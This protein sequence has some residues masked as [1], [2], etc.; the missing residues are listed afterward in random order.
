M[1]TAQCVVAVSSEDRTP[2]PQTKPSSKREVFFKRRAPSLVVPTTGPH[3]L[4]LASD[5][6]TPFEA[7][8]SAAAFRRLGGT[9]AAEA[10]AAGCD[11]AEVYA[12]CENWQE[13][14]KA[15]SMALL[16][17]DGR[18]VTV[19]SRDSDQ[20]GPW[21]LDGASVSTD[22]LRQNYRPVRW[23]AALRAALSDEQMLGA[24]AFCA[25]G[26]TAAEAE[27][28]G[29]PGMAVYPLCDRFLDS[30]KANSMR[31]VSPDGAYVTVTSRDDDRSGPWVLDGE[32]VG[33]SEFARRNIRPL[34]WASVFKMLST[35]AG[36]MRC[37]GAGTP[38]DAEAAGC[39][40]TDVY[41]LCARLQSS[42]KA[43]SMRMVSSDG[44]F[45]TVTSSD[46]DENGPWRVE[47]VARMGSSSLEASQCFERTTFLRGL[48]VVQ[49]LSRAKPFNNAHTNGVPPNRR[50]F[51]H[52]MRRLSPAALGSK[53]TGRARRTA[54]SP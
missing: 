29:Q 1:S 30:D 23:G 32:Q 26:K 22:E 6:R 17:A 27:A 43:N 16:T 37:C 10:V 15:N 38:S 46:Q 52:T 48:S 4:A 9:T 35:P 8:L 45:V 44:A 34:R 40:G 42:D 5:A 13:R 12:L 28:A 49:S 31:M 47:S 11:L 18:R 3:R 41:S 36:R 50:P 7:V 25:S 33:S 14:D 54:K 21:R 2:E 19:T 53:Q 20:C 24:E 51:S 39:S